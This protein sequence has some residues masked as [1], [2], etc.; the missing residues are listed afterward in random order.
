MEWNNA[1]RQRDIFEQWSYTNG[2]IRIKFNI[3]HRIKFH[4]PNLVVD[5]HGDAYAGTIPN[6]HTIFNA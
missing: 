2:F 6:V 3:D 5:F 4:Y 1:E